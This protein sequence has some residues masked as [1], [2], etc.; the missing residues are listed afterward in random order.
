MASNTNLTTRIDDLDLD[1]SIFEPRKT[2]DPVLNDFLSNKG[3]VMPATATMVTGDPGSGKTTLVC[4]ILSDI[5]QSGGDALFISM[6]MNEIDMASYTQRFPHWGNL[7]IY[8]PD[9][10][11]DI[12]DDVSE[13]IQSGFDMVAIDSFKELKDIIADEKGWTKTRTEREL[14]TLMNDAMVDDND[15]GTHTC[16]YVIQQVLKSG[17]FAGSKRLEHLMTAN[18][19]MVVEETESYLMFEKNRRGDAHRKLFYRIKENEIV[20]DG[21]RRE[22][23]EEAIDFVEKEQE[24]QQQREQEFDGIDDL[25]NGSSSG[26]NMPET[27]PRPGMEN[28][29]ADDDE[30]AEIRGLAASVHD[31]LPV[32]KDQ[33]EP[34]VYERVF[35]YEDGNV[36]DV[37]DTL[38]DIGVVEESLTWYYANKLAKEQ[39]LK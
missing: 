24:R 7:D 34:Q 12:W 33:I 16:F 35:D 3:G 18:L 29:T 21:D 14:I 39:G 2:S 1:P 9:F 19:K 38:V 22:T 32:E 30:L 28:G 8:F 25:L 26:Q 13:L 6:E 31:S 4:E 36:S 20:F 11:R 17:D 37:A 10:E 23:E 5:Q 27:E 15:T